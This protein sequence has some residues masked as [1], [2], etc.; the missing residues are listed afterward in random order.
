M[1]LPNFL[2]VGCAKSGTTSIDRS[3]SEHPD[4]FMCSPKE[5]RYFAY[6]DVRPDYRGPHDE[7]LFNSTTVWKWE[8]YCNRFW[9]A[10]NY[11][12][13]GESSPMYM[14]LDGVATRIFRTLPDVKIIIFLRNPV[15]RAFSAYLHLVRDGYETFSFEDALDAEPARVAEGWAWHWRYKSLGFVAKQLSEYFQVFPRENIKVILYE[16]FKANNKA[17]L[18][19]LFGFLGVA[20]GIQ[21]DSNRENA[22]GIPRMRWLQSFL[23]SKSSIKKYIGFFL[24]RNF[25]D[26]MLRKLHK[27]NLKRVDIGA[28]GPKTYNKLLDEFEDDILK[29]STLIERDLSSWLNRKLVNEIVEN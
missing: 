29:T 6:P 9:D 11:I 7:E 17:V 25:K 26:K 15:E 23:V 28:I 4:I 8:D 18:N 3:L 2:I 16:D 21:L 13:V 24:T 22:G 19:D 27:I 12:A 20:Q 14:V 10:D 5:P 1:K